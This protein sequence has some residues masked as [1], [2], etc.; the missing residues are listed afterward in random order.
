MNTRLTNDKHT[1]LNESIAYV[2]SHQR[3]L[4]EAVEYARALEEVLL[5]LCEELGID[6]AALVEDIQTGE[7]ENEMFYKRRSLQDKE[8][9]AGDRAV[10]VLNSKNKDKKKELNKKWSAAKRALEKHDR[11]DRVEKDSSRLYG[12]GGKVVKKGTVDRNPY[13]TAGW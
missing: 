10:S 7:R 8:E 13:R 3:E 6:P 11:R 2:S 5:A 1:S 12:K 4:D 9:S